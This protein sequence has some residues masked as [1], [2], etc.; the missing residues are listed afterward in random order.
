MSSCQIYSP[1]GIPTTTSLPQ[2]TEKKQGRGC[3]TVC[4]VQETRLNPDTEN[5]E[6]S[7]VMA[8]ENNKSIKSNYDKARIELKQENNK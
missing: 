1:V 5:G 8:A 7:S 3:S 2:R 6:Q 4:S